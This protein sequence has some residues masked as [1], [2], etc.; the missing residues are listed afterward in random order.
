M[1]RRARERVRREVDLLDGARRGPHDPQQL[2]ALASLDD[3]A[4]GRPR[5]ARSR[6]C[7]GPDGPSTS[8]RLE[9]AAAHREDELAALAPPAAEQRLELGGSGR[10]RSPRLGLARA[11][12]STAAF[13]RS[14]ASASGRPPAPV[15][16]STAA[17]MPV[18]RSTSS[19]ARNPGMAPP[20]PTKT[21]SPRRGRA[22]GPVPH[23][24]RPALVV[25]HRLHVRHLL[26]RR[27]GE[28][29]VRRPRRGTS[30]SVRGRGGRPELAERAR[31]AEG[32]ARGS[33]PDA[34]RCT[35]RR[36]SRAPRAAAAVGVVRESP[37]GSSTRA[38]SASSHGAAR[39]AAP[40]PRPAARRPGSSS[41]TTSRARAAARRR[42][43][44]RQLLAAR[45]AASSPRSRPA[46]RAGGRT[47]AR[48]CGRASARARSPARSP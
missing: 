6:R 48:A 31:S 1:A 16:V 47:R 4:T 7:R 38:C 2:A 40:R 3:T 43:C 9:A 28:H 42:P 27:G 33:T 12:A 35:A 32:R 44:P 46:A 24:E 21:W 26:E 18:S 23:A 15:F 36:S 29:A 25:D 39:R 45:A 5:A 41:A 22:R 13:G 14:S 37:S 30:P 20:W 34:R 10:I 11:A 17:P 8:T 19:M